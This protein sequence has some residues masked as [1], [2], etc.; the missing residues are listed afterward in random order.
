M[1]NQAAIDIQR[2]RTDFPILQTRVHGTKPLVYFD[3]GASSQRP[4]AV[5][6]AISRC[7]EQ[8]YSNV[9][10]G[11]H[12][13]SEAATSAYE[14]ARVKLAHLIGATNQYEVIFTSGTTMAINMVAH[15]WGNDHIDAGD[16][17]LLTLFEHH[18]NIV[19]WQ[20]LAQRKG[21]KVRFA[22]LTSDGRID[23]DQ[24]RD[25]INERT[26]MVAF[27]AVS[28]VLGTIAP[29]TE[30]LAIARES[31]ATT[32]VD[33]AQHAP[34]EPLDVNEWN[35]DFITFSGHKM[36]GPSGIGVLWGRE[37]I[38]ET[39]PPFMGG[40]SM[41]SKVTTE[42]FTP[43]ELPARFEAGTPPIAQAI[44]FGAAV[45]YLQA[46]GMREIAAH[47]R[48]LAKH[49]YERLSEIDRVQILGPAPEHRA[50]LVSFVVEGVSALD[51]A[52]SLDRHG[53][54]VRAGHHCAMPLHHHLGHPASVRASFYLYNDTDEI[55]FFIEKL[56][57]E[58]QLLTG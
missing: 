7:Y 58:I 34:H 11:I 12:A 30:M 48:H 53:I 36:L 26:K 29:T 20:Q 23:L 41:I 19:P 51:I 45:D 2:V 28:N 13:L 50:G 38:L 35:A 56:Q 57:R 46:I 55:D 22:S 21:A 47:E 42:G 31:G 37:A 3:S 24:F 10:R 40:G 14:E 18:S 39:L 44:G 4:Q 16:E 1:L 49:A 17:I 32:L 15:A 43:G 6:D 27:S 9:H 8:Q 33:A 5:I 52:F 25:Q 54:A